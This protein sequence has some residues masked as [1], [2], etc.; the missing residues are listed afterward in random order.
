MLKSKILKIIREVLE[1]YQFIEVTTPVLRKGTNEVFKRHTVILGNDHIEKFAYLRDSLECPLRS[2]LQ[3]T[4]RVY[5]IGPCFR[6]DP[7]DNQHYPEFTLLE[8]YAEKTD[9]EFLLKLILEIIERIYLSISSPISINKISIRESIRDILGID[10]SNIDGNQLKENIIQVDEL[11][12]GKYRNTP[13]YIC[14]NEFISK[15][16]EVASGVNVFYEYPASTISSARRISNTQL[17][18]RFEIFIN[19]VEVAHGYMDE[20]DLD[21]YEK[22][23]REVNL[24]NFEEKLITELIQSKNLC[25]DTG[26]FGLGIERLCSV[27]SSEDIANY[28]FGKDFNYLSK[29]NL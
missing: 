12:Y 26:G 24:Y 7:V 16:F 29:I 4:P 14:I 1:H 10:I 25:P 5:E 13:H 21:D 27:L 28:I 15:N 20:I 23:G 11:N 6:V 18:E 17:I 8:V 2:L 19:G 22:R 3:H 9:F